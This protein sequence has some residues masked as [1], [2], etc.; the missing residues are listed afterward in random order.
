MPSD[1]L[2]L[3]KNVL[4]FLVT[5][6]PQAALQRL[7]AAYHRWTWHARDDA[8]TVVVLGGSFAGIEL[9]R[10]LCET[11]PTG[12]RVVLIEKN[13]HLN[14]SFV[15]PRFAVMT[16]QEHKAFIPYDDFE[17][18]V[19]A[20]M[21]SRVRDVAVGITENQV[22]LKSGLPVAYDLLAIA[23]GSSQPLPAQAA[24][25]DCEDA[26]EELR[27]VQRLIGQSQR[28]AVVGGGAV[29]VELAGDIKDF[30]PEKEVTLVHSRGELLGNFG[31]RLQEHALRVLRDELGVR[32][33]LNER[34][35]M[36]AGNLVQNDSLV[37][38]DGHTEDF[39]L[40]VSS[41]ASH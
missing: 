26:C 14:Y 22:L 20:G 11:L 2:V 25:T 21:L 33:I 41:V 24:S 19:P 10:R 32:V 28:I 34:P 6:L 37:F 38:S 12:Y 30:H 16:G 18:G 8:K 4:A 1:T 35:K 3:A 7:A 17:R 15:F 36:P 29:G 31:S 9:V 40:I 5:Y 39:D 23:T 13:S 27:K